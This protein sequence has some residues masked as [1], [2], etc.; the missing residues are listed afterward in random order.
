MRTPLLA[1]AVLALAACVATPRILVTQPGGTSPAGLESFEFR[2]SKVVLE[3]GGWGERADGQVRDK[4]LRAL[5]GKG[6]REAPAGAAPDFYVTCRIAVFLSE[7]P[8]DPYGMPRDPT[9][10]IGPEPATDAA[11]SEGLVRQATLVLMTQTPGDDR[12]LWQ[13]QASG[14]AASRSELSTGAMRAIDQM[15]RPFPT[16]SP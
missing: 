13:A 8:R 5:T 16:R 9:T 12:V 3:S 2:S 14:V 15:L 4:V 6:Y 11:G 7:S 10:L 1:A